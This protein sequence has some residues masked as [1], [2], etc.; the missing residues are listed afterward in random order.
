[1]YYTISFIKKCYSTY[2]LLNKNDVLIILNEIKKSKFR[3]KR[4]LIEREI[5]NIKNS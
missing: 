2:D 4:F 5:M 1:L 3:V